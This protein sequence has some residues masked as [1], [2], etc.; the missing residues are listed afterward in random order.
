MRDHGQR[1]HA[2]LAIEIGD[3]AQPL[4]EACVVR[5]RMTVLQSPDDER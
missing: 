1:V 4:D 5:E 2:V 3:L